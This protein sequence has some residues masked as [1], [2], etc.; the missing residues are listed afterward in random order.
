M[1]ATA[2]NVVVL[3]GDRGPGDPLAAGAGVPGKV[4][5]EIGGKPMLTRVLEA[6]GGFGN[7]GEVIVVCRDLPA[8]AAAIDAACRC[9]RIDPAEGPAA[10]AMA[11]LDQIDQAGPVLLVTGDHPL[12][13]PEWLDQ[14]VERACATGADAAVG[15]VDHAAIVER[16]PDSKRTRYRFSD[17]SICG[18][19]LFY[20]AGSGG[21]RVIEQWRAFETDRKKPWKIVGRL[22]PWNLLRYLLGRLSLAQAL[23]ALSRRLGVRLAAVEIDWPEAAVDVDSPGDLDLVVRLIEA[24]EPPAS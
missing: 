6:V 18:T 8:Y 7:H 4:L 10:S 15:V 14:F 3:A 16:F 17:V 11:A 13:R 2:V 12:L 22:G 23:E 9:R 1:T 20:F 21:R 5:V 24:R 19:N